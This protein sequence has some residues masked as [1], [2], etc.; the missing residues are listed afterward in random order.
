MGFDAKG[1]GKAV[2]AII[3][4]SEITAWTGETREREILRRAIIALSS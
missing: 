4:S 2:S 1:A 3:E